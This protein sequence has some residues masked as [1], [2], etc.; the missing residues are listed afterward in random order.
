MNQRETTAR[1]GLG[2]AA[3][4][5]PAYIT[6]GR[7]EDLGRRTVAQMERRSHEVLDT[8]YE[9]GV[10]YVDVARSYGLAEAFLS[11]WLGSRDIPFGALTWDP[12]GSTSTPAAGGWTSTSTR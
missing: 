6:A 8:A 1:V 11:S 7:D 3:L 4:G 2:L 12:S 10:R 5:R 9:A